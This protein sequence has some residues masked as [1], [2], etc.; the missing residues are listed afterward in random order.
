MA[1]GPEEALP[2]LESLTAADALPGYHLLPAARADALRRL[3]RA[4]EAAVAYRTA[5]D[6]APNATERAF[7][8]RRRVEL[9]TEA[10][11]RLS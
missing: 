4:A 5:A 11:R 1:L 2:I 6:L 8:V 7:L 3:G 9:E 10:R